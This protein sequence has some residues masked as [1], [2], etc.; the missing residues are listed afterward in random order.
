MSQERQ[1]SRLRASLKHCGHCCRGC[2]CGNC[3]SGNCVSGNC[4]SGNCV[5]SNWA[6]RRWLPGLVPRRRYEGAA[7][8]PGDLAGLLAGLHGTMIRPTNG[9]GVGRGYQMHQIQVCRTAQ[10]A[11]DRDLV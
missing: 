6:S 4:V 1:P 9:N 11:C 5:C 10:D 8:C 3:V 7:G 2:A